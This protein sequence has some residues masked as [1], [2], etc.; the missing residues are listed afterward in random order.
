MANNIKW[1]IFRDYIYGLDTTEFNSETGKVVLYDTKKWANQSLKDYIHDVNYAHAIGYMEEPYQNDCEV[2]KV[3][4]LE[5]EG[6][7]VDYLTHVRYNLINDLNPLTL[8]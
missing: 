8:S 5:D 7:I 2:R 6:V 3:R 4:V 1:C